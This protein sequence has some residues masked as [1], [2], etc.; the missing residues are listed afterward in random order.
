MAMGWIGSKVNTED[1]Y[2]PI[3]EL[4][5]NGHNEPNLFRMDDEAFQPIA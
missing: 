1:F 2:V 3:G 5:L 4:Y